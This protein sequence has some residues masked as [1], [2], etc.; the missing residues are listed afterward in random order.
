L[1]NVIHLDQNLRRR[2]RVID[3]ASAYITRLDAGASDADREEIRQ[4]LTDSELHRT[5]FL[6]M[7]ALWDELSVLDSLEEMFPMDTLVP[8]PSDRPPLF[9]KR[10]IAAGF[11]LVMIGT[12]A[13]NLLAPPADINSIA[14]PESIT[15]QVHSTAQG[16]QKSVSL[17]DGTT[18]VLNTNSRVIIKDAPEGSH[19]FLEQGEAYLDVAAGSETALRVFAGR[20]MIE[21]KGQLSLM[22]HDTDSLEILVRDGS[23][24]RTFLPETVDALMGQDNVDSILSRTWS[25]FEIRSGQLVNLLPAL[26]VD[27]PAYLLEAD[28]VEAMLAW[29]DGRINFDNQTVDQVFEALGRYTGL[30][31]DAVDTVRDIPIRGT[32]TV[33]DTDGLLLSLR[34]LY[35]IQSMQVGENHI[36]LYGGPLAPIQ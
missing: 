30:R 15:L 17:A 27:S 2:E 16:E 5:V 31:V 6:E 22:R 25:P 11:A 21:P 10:C 26:P 33:G 34:E 32:Y 24:T 20:Q 9:G 29:T 18:I 13:W 1:S 36:L 3:Q 35:N 28:Q 8:P 19:V 7:A 23:A 14:G 12:L 4:W